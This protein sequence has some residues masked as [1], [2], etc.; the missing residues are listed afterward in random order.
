M[1]K[2]LL[3]AND[4]SRYEHSETI[5]LLDLSKYEG[6]EEIE[7]DAEAIEKAIRDHYTTNWCQHGHDCCGCWRTSVTLVALDGWRAVV[8]LLH[9]QNV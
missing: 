2:A 7:D 9:T 1:F 5:L 6:E 4:G 3:K 8:H